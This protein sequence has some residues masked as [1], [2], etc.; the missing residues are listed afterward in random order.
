MTINKERLHKIYTTV[1][2]PLWITISVFI[3]VLPFFLIQQINWGLAAALGVVAAAISQRDEHPTS[4]TRSMIVM[5][6]GFTITTCCASLLKPYPVL[7]TIGL[8]VSAMAF[9]LIGGISQ[10]LRAIS[11]GAI[12]ISIYATIV[13]SSNEAWYVKPLLLNMGAIVY[14]VLSWILLVRKPRKPLAKHLARGYEALADYLEVKS[15]LL[16]HPD[17]RYVREQQADKNLAVVAAL[18]NAKDVL[19]N[20]GQYDNQEKLMI[21]MQQFMLL[22]SLHERATSSHDFYEQLA[23]DRTYTDILQGI[24]ELMHQLSHASRLVAE[25]IRDGKEYEHPVAI[26][27]L[28]ESLENRIKQLP[29][30]S[31]QNLELLLHNLWRSHINLSKINEQVDYTAM[32]ELEKEERSAWQRLISQINLNDSR[33]RYAIRLSLC[34]VIGT[35]IGYLGHFQT[36]EWIPLTALFVSQTSYRETRRRFSQRVAGTILGLILGATALILLP[37]SLGHLVMLLAATFA[38]FWWLPKN[39]AIAVI[40]ITMFV[41]EASALD[42]TGG[43]S[44]LWPRLVDTCIGAVLSFGVMRLLWPDWQH[45]R[46]P[47]LMETAM[48]ANVAYFDAIMQQWHAGVE[49]DDLAYRVVR[50]KAHI[51]DNAITQARRSI[52]IEPK[53]GQE[54]VEILMRH[55]YQNHALLSYISALGAHRHSQLSQN[56]LLK[57]VEQTIRMHMAGASNKDTLSNCIHQLKFEIKRTPTKEQLQTYRLFYN[58]AYLLSQY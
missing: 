20:Y 29:Q 21:Y 46:L 55:A 13:F 52:I 28:I 42:G 38:F 15:R 49:N 45:K 33:M 9:V 6:T 53:K 22:Q 39:Y 34:F 31:N 43:W 3:V 32:P 24:A 57:Q 5:L 14:S 41:L 56:D 50:R 11:Y 8:G 17:A 1:E 2:S 27:W 26:S 25:H 16:I 35:M 4:R 54:S 36:P 19:N 40:F 44:I 30:T 37:T 12:L 51:A 7:F 47:A 48:H 58:I 23:K 10:H 18:E